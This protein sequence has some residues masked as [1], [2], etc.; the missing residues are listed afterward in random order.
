MAG[1]SSLPLPRESKSTDTS[2]P[3]T[4]VLAETVRPS[5]RIFVED[6]RRIFTAEEKPIP[7][8]YLVRRVFNTMPLGSGPRRLGLELNVRANTWLPSRMV[9]T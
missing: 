7:Q 1:Y 3:G 8:S 2:D 5:R 9:S 4:K 6:D